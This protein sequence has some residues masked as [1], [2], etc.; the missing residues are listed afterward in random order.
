LPQ[1]CY[2]RYEFSRLP[3]YDRRNDRIIWRWNGAVATAC[4]GVRGKDELRLLRFPDFRGF[5][6]LGAAALGVAL[7]GLTSLA[8]SARAET[9]LEERKLPMKFSWV[10]CE[11]NCR[12]WVSAVGVVTSDSPADFDRFARGRDLSGST[13]VLDS[14]G[15]SV[16]DAITL[17]RR[18]RTLGLLTTV[19]TSI[20]TH[21]AQGDQASIMPDAYC[22]SMCVF[23]LLSGKTRYVPDGAH[24]RVHQIWMGDRAD[25]AKSASYTA[26]DLM[27]VERDVGRLAKYTFDMGGAGDL[28]ALS[29]SVPPWENL[30]EL[31]RDELRQTNLVTT[32]VVAEVLPDMMPKSGNAATPVA[33]L[34]TP[35]SV[36]DRFVSSAMQ[37]EAQ[38]HQIALPPKSTRTAEAMPPTGAVTTPAK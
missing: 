12:G 30:H 1:S 22:E 35:K 4:I 2:G 11:P 10:V 16:N 37:A 18:W 8:G 20:E 19:G 38:P 34:T 21:S 14:S 6:L 7:P 23:L 33:E 28:L 5:A 17:G 27:I 29:L 13:V 24:V 15:G 26:Q 31:S 3:F 25:D 32:D 36:Q 9:A